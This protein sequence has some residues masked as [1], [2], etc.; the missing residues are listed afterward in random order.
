M[1]RRHNLKSEDIYWYSLRQ[2]DPS[3]FPHP[4]ALWKWHVGSACF[5]HRVTSLVTQYR[6]PRLQWHRLQWH[7]KEMIAYK[8]HFFK[9][10]NDLSYSK[11][12][13]I[14]WHNKKHLAYSDTVSGAC[15]YTYTQWLEARYPRVELLSFWVTLLAPSQLHKVIHYHPEP[16]LPRARGP[17]PREIVFHPRWA[18]NF[19]T[20]LASETST[21]RGKLKVA[22]L[23]NPPVRLPDAMKRHQI[24][25]QEKKALFQFR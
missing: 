4:H 13:W 15:T 5:T 25:F 24:I 21:W 16:E 3:R 6:A 7:S 19:L 12:V 17:R 14:Q 23:E 2:T 20:S 22:E 18:Q 11:T 10:P 9:F 8:W 1:S